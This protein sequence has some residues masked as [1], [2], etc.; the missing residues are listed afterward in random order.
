MANESPRG[1]WNYVRLV[2][3]MG[4]MI[5]E[6][7]THEDFDGLGSS[8]ESR[9]WILSESKLFSR[10]YEQGKEKRDALALVQRRV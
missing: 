8:R 6:K 4:Y 3:E 5:D 1:I 7:E 9:N 2:G 10:E